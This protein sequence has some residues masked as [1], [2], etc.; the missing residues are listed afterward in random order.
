MGRTK[1]S[2]EEKMFDEVEVDETCTIASD[3]E[4]TPN[5]SSPDW[6]EFIF[7]KLTK[8]E[9]DP[10]GKFPKTD[11]LPRLIETYI[12]P[13]LKNNSKIIVHPTSDNNQKVMVEHNIIVRDELYGI[14]RE[15][16]SVG[17]A[18]ELKLVQPYNLY[19]GPIS[20]TRAMGRSY[21][22]ILQLR[23]VTTHEE[24]S[25]SVEQNEDTITDNQIK[26]IEVMCKRLSINMEELLRSKYGKFSHIKELD[27][28]F[29]KSIL[30]FLTK[31]EQG[32]EI[33]ER[34]VKNG[35][36]IQI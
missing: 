1:K 32:E 21:K 30:T 9:L 29:A 7:S 24:I 5:R 31:V 20:S 4:K 10:T 23:G 25:G 6:S 16:T 33:Y 14:D 2:L 27:K 15:V 12:G 3:G 8:D 13:I 26:A 35:N 36:N 19:S 34:K 18:S 28:E 17:E 11:A 22:V